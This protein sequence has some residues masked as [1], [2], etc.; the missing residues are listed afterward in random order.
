V[1]FVFVIAAVLL[2]SVAALTLF[3]VND[4]ETRLKAQIEG[5][6]KERRRFLTDKNYNRAKTLA[7]LERRT[8][9]IISMYN[10]LDSNQ[11]QKWRN[12]VASIPLMLT[13]IQ[14]WGE[15]KRELRE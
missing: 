7:R 3:V 4:T 6:V 9:I 10:K 14:R 13:R 15:I 11:Q 5:W 8:D 2:I 1:T 12:K